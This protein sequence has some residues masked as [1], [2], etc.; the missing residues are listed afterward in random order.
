M[1]PGVFWKKNVRRSSR[2]SFAD[3]R[4]EKKKL[5]ALAR[6]NALPSEP[7]VRRDESRSENVLDGDSSIFVYLPVLNSAEDR[8]RIDPILK[9]DPDLKAG[10]GYAYEI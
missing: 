2:I 10:N 6:Q 1:G 5:K 3:D 4:E 9:S 7:D 8:K